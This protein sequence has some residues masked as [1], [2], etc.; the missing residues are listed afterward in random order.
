MF[1]NSGPGVDGWRRYQ[2]SLCS[3][4]TTAL[5][6]VCL[7][8]E[9]LASFHAIEIRCNFKTF[10]DSMSAISNAVSIRDMISKRQ[11]PNNADCITTIKDAT[12]VY[13]PNVT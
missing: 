13:Q 10:I 6:S 5:S 1:V 9:K 8:L 4:A 11:Y 12:R 7:Y 2:S 3:E